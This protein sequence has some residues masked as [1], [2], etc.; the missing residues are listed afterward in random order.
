MGYSTDCFV[1]YHHDSDIIMRKGYSN[2]V[3]MCEGSLAL[4]ENNM[5]DEAMLVVSSEKY[6]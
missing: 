2:R 4:F 5:G 6:S 3:R 1:L